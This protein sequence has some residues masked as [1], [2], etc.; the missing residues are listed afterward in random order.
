MSIN[1]IAQKIKTWLTSDVGQT[2]STISIIIIVGIGSFLLG[3]LSKSNLS[4]PN[5]ATIP[6]NIAKN[7]QNSQIT[8]PS[9]PSTKIGQNSQNG[10]YI[11]SKNGTKY[12]PNGCS[13]I[14][15]IK[16]ENRIS[17]ATEQ[18]AIASGRTKSS[19]CK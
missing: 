6:I 9:S 5:N 7:D 17:F 19:T 2:I 15:K 11:A 1:D 18:E 14:N 4:E 3:R 16:V 10:A 13:G 8:D 12:Y